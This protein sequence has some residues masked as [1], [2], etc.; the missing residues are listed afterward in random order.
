VQRLHRS[1]TRPYAENLTTPSAPEAHSAS[2]AGRT[3]LSGPASTRRPLRARRSLRI[4]GTSLIVLGLCAVAWTIV[5]WRWQDPFTAL[6]TLYEQHK[7]SGRY[8]KIEKSYHPLLVQRSKSAPAARPSFNVAEERRLI[9]LDAKRYRSTLRA[10]TPLGR[11]KIHRLGNFVLVTGT[12]H[13]SLTKGPGWDMLTYLPG[14][15]KLIYIAGHRTT[16]LAPFAHIDSLRP[17]DLVRIEVPYGTFVYRVHNHVIVPADDLARLR[18][19]N[20]PAGTP[21]GEVVALQACHP[22]FFATHRYIAYAVLARV[23]PK[24]GKAY[25]VG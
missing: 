14:E 21:A 20:R 18:S 24:G 22:R 6:Y 16:Y 9:Q 10:G 8:H 4:L 23:V 17:G 12:D 2:S 11:I 1:L 7:L 25:S 3:A 19:S 15:G 13:D 5:V